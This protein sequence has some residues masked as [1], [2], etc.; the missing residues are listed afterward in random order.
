MDNMD[1]NV[2]SMTSSMHV[3]NNQFTDMNRTVGNMT[4]NMSQM[5]KPMKVFPFQAAP[6]QAHADSRGQGSNYGR[7]AT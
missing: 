1:G 3:L 6:D 4:S 7:T 5:A 2:G